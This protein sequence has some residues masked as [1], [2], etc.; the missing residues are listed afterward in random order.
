MLHMVNTLFLSAAYRT[1]PGSEWMMFWLSSLPQFHQFRKFSVS[2][3]GLSLEN[4]ALEVVNGRLMNEGLRRRTRPIRYLPSYASSYW[5]W[6]KGRYVTISRT[7]EGNR[8]NSDK[9]TLQITSV[10]SG[11]ITVIVQSL[12]DSQ[13]IF[14]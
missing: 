13:N 4:S 3:S 11:Y 14:P 8:W 6:Y 9:S 7:K 10:S 12:K 1:D 5:M 2:T